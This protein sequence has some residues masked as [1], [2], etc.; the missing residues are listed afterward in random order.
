[1]RVVTIYTPGSLYDETL[2][3]LELHVLGQEVNLEL[4]EISADDPH[5][6]A[7]VLANHWQTGETFMVVE[8]DIV[9]RHDVIEAFRTCGCP[10]GCYPYPWLTDVGPAL[11][12][13]WFKAEFLAKYPAAMKG[14]QDSNVSWNQVDV[15]LMRHILARHYKEQPH[16]HLP[17]VQHLNPKK[18]LMEGRPTEPL[19]TVPEW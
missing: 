5:A 6:Y 12:C 10:Y 7:R 1:V 15:V 3:A 9:V 14:V 2:S 8:P 4:T 16:V 11:G 19:T 18:Q 17:A 13:T